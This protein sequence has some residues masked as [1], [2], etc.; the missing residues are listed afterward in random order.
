MKNLVVLISGSGRNLQALIEHCAAGHIPAR[1]AAVVSNKAEAYGLERARRAGIATEVVPHG[2]YPSREAFD[3]ALAAAIDRH[4]PDLLAMAGFMRILTPGFTRRYLGRA[5]NIHPSLLPRHPGLKTHAAA[6]AAGDAEHGASVHF[7]T[8]ALD[9]GPLVLQG[10]FTV[11]PEDSAESLAER[12]MNEVEL[13]IY[14]QALA[15]LARGDLQLR[16]DLA[17]LQGAPLSQP[18]TLADLEEPF[19]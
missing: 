8:E 4:A 14:P 2:D 3:A 15:W 5:L 9:G 17:W 1:I 18:R 12:V 16:G 6:L 10:A 7:V 13:K 19:R 11:A